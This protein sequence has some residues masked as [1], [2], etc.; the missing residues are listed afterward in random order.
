MSPTPSLEI[1]GLNR[2]KPGE[3]LLAPPPRPGLL[4]F[5]GID[6][7]RRNWHELLT[8]HHEDPPE[9]PSAYQMLVLLAELQRM[10]DDETARSLIDS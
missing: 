4:A 3:L 8:R 9:D 1:L 6:E 2:P 5:A 10:E 7:D